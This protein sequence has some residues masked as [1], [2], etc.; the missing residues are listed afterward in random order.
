MY[1]FCTMRHQWHPYAN[2]ALSASGPRRA[3][4]QTEDVRGG[5]GERKE[6]NI[7]FAI[8]DED[9]ENKS[10]LRPIT[11]RMAFSATSTSISSRRP[12]LSSETG[13]GR[14]GAHGDQENKFEKCRGLTTG[15]RGDQWMR[16]PGD[17]SLGSQLSLIR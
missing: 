4:V 1:I 9:S 2:P 8:G 12:V 6:R 15:G 17:W 3:I 7:G 5:E 11:Q 14:G 16:C 10:K 13:E